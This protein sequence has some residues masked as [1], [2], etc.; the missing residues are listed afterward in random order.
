MINANIK[1]VWAKNN[2]GALK[3]LKNGHRKLPLE[4]IKL[5]QKTTPIKYLLFF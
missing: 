3:Y 4:Q 1:Y 5:L 2:G